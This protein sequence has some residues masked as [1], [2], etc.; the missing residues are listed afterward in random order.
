[1]KIKLNKENAEKLNLKEGQKIRIQEDIEAFY[2]LVEYIN[3]ITKR[4]RE[5][6]YKKIDTEFKKAIRDSRMNYTDIDN[7][8]EN[9]LSELSNDEIGF[10]E[11]YLYGNY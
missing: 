6:L 4:D 2:E 5:A 9:M 10:I 8:I 1:M 3:N 7:Y 11:A